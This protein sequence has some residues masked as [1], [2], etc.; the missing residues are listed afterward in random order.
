MNVVDT[1]IKRL[2]EKNISFGEFQL[3]N[4]SP[5]KESV[6]F[7]NYTL[8]LIDE[9]GGFFGEVLLSKRLIT[10]Y[11]QDLLMK[12]NILL[13]PEF[14]EASSII[15]LSEILNKIDENFNIHLEISSDNTLAKVSTTDFLIGLKY[16]KVF[17]PLV[18]RVDTFSIFKLLLKRDIEIENIVEYSISIHG[19]R[20]LPLNIIGVLE[21]GAMMKL[22]CE[23]VVVINDC[24]ELSKF[25]LFV[26]EES[27]EEKILSIEDLRL[28][29]SVRIEMGELNFSEIKGLLS[30]EKKIDLLQGKSCKLMLGNS[31]M[32]MGEVD[33][34]QIRITKTFI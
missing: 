25:N 2:L 20:R 9:D 19:L 4:I 3:L 21:E 1:L 16:K 10:A 15:L 23:N 31:L 17:S 22:P 33:E 18:L 12:K 28:P 13:L 24:L 14:V 26:E 32:A 11:A 34:T 7:E 6:E 30:S 27:M 8:N 29:V 5:L